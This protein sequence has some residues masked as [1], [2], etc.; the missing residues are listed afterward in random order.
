MQ[1]SNFIAIFYSFGFRNPWNLRWN[2]DLD[3]DGS[4]GG[5][6]GGNGGGDGGNNLSLCLIVGH[7]VFDSSFVDDGTKNVYGAEFKSLRLCLDVLRLRPKNENARIPN[8]DVSHSALRLI[9]SEFTLFEPFLHETTKLFDFCLRLF[10]LLLES[11]SLDAI[12]L[13]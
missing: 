6:G 11:C 4:G 13:N 2:D 12:E 3:G 10:V 1:F 5:G 9:L 8:V 7:F